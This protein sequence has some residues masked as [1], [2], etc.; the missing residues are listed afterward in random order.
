MT[1]A[2]ILALVVL[3][4]SYDRGLD[5]EAELGR[6]FVRGFV[7]VLAMG[8]IIGLL[9]S[10]PFA[11]SAVVILA[12]VG[13]AAWISKDRGEGIPGVLRV[14]LVSIFAGAGL[15]IVTMLAAGAIEPTIRNLIPVGG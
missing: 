7:Q 5:L 6:A 10:L 14:S 13:A 9:F 3:G 4:I 1:A 12:M 2:T 15:V 11:W 8:A